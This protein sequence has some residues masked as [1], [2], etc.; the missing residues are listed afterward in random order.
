MK[1]PVWI[2]IAVAICA[3]LIS[4]WSFA[5][6]FILPKPA[7]QNPAIVTPTPIDLDLP[8]FV[9]VGLPANQWVKFRVIG[10]KPDAF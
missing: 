2:A 4:S 7:I 10:S 5:A 3:C 6:N 9:Y 1:E 8:E